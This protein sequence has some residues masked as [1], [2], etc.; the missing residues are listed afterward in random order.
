MPDEGLRIALPSKGRIEEGTRLF[1]DRVGFPVRRPN[2]RQYVGTLRG[3]PDVSVLFQRASDIVTKVETGLADVG[4]TGLD[5]VAEHQDDNESVLVLMPDLGFSRCR[6]VIE[7]PEAW[8]D[9]TTIADLADLAADFRARGR[10]LRVITD[11]PNLVKDFLYAR[12]IT[13]FVV[14]E[15]EGG[16]EA[17]PA[18]DTA[19]IVADRTE[20]GT[21]LRDNRLKEVA[22]GTIME[23]QACLIGNRRQLRASP[24]KRQQLR[25]IMEFAEAHL[26]SRRYR[27]LTANVRGDSAAEVATHVI[28][29]VETAGTLGPTVAPVFPKTPILPSAAT[30]PVITALETGW[31]AVSLVVEE[32]LLLPAIDHLRRAGSGGITVGAPEYVFEPVSQA[33]AAMLDTLGLPQELV[34]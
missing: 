25:H 16:L 26:R 19:D 30:G 9:I 24:T 28:Q 20:T 31:Y 1:F 33:Y 23:T 18:I 12:G 11:S 5:F 3:I 8:V 32:G 13:Y 27:T 14:I 10:T 21:T 15:G 22:G 2:A 6:F 4:I 29:Q 17:A 7:V 34:P